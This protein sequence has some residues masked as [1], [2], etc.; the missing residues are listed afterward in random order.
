YEV[1]RE[2]IPQYGF[3]IA[4]PLNWRFPTYAWVLS[5]LPNKCWIQAVLLLLAVGGM[6]MTFVAESRR[7]S[8]LQAG[9]TTFLMF[10]VVR[11]TFDGEAYLAQE[12]W[13]G[14]LMVVSSA[15]GAIA[16]Q[17]PGVRGQEPGIR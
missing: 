6:G 16:S 7:S 14:V 3:P 9:V 2:K 1:A 12:V 10:G 13:A 5:R 17:G 8:V 15:A 4:S 11:W